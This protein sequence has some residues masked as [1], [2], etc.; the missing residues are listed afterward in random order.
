M[1]LIRRSL[2]CFVVGVTAFGVAGWG[3]RP[4]PSAVAAVQGETSNLESPGEVGAANPPPPLPPVLQA[5][6]EERSCLSR[7]PDWIEGTTERFVERRGEL[8]LWLAHQP[9]STTFWLGVDDGRQPILDWIP[10][11]S[12][13]AIRP[14]LFPC[15]GDPRDFPR[16]LPCQPT[17]AFARSGTG[18]IV[19]ATELAPT[20]DLPEGV[21]AMI[22]DTS[23]LF[24]THVVARWCDTR[25]KSWRDIGARDFTDFDVTDESLVTL[26]MKGEDR[27]RESWPLPPRDPKWPA[28]GVAAFFTAA[29]WWLCAR[30]YRRTLNRAAIPAVIA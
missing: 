20:S 22:P 9:L 2:L 10:Y 11:P 21:V 23:E 25:N 16:V 5:A 1:R 6:P 29:T 28:L 13:V 7:L 12:Q 19:V 18:I 27:L 3:F 17:A 4:K 24:R 8:R 26:S 15:V 14:T 30:R